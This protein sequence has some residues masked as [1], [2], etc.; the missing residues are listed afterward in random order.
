MVEPENI[1]VLIVDDHPVVRHG[2]SAIVETDISLTVVG[3]ASDGLDALDRV[4]ALRPHVVLMDIHMPRM[5]GLM[6][7]RRVKEQFPSVAVIVLTLYNNDQYVV[8]AVKAGAAGYLLKT[9]TRDEICHTIREVNSGGLLIRTTTLQKALSGSLAPDMPGTAEP[10]G[11]RWDG[12]AEFERLSPRELDVLRLVVEG[13]TNK[14]IGS[15]LY[16]TEDTAKKHVQNIIAKLQVSDRTQAAV[17]ALR[18]GLAK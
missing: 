12:D 9:A 8:E 1:R 11:R 6:A 15:V 14:D 16:I 3:E 4:A 5:D 2:L 17:K 13:M 7:T 18:L 10:R